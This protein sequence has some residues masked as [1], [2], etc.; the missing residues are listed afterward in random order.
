MLDRL[1]QAADTQ[2]LLVEEA[3]HELR[4][5]I[6]VLTTNAEV[7]LAHPD[8]T[9]ALY[10]EGIERSAAAARRL[11][12]TIEDLLVDAR[13]RARTLDRR[14]ADLVAVA[15]AAVDDA[16]VLAAAGGVTLVAGGPTAAPCAV[17]EPTVR[18]AVGNLLANAVRH[19]PA[20]TTV[21]VDVSV[22]DGD[23]EDEVAVSVTDHG[24]GIPGAEQGRAFERFWRGPDGSGGTGLG[25]PI[26]R[27]IARAHGGDVTLRSPGP[28]G[29][30]TVATITLRRAL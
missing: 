19:A 27:Q 6:A 17:D 18:R 21:S 2:R 24:P 26:A 1:E 30:G 10:R 7:V 4:T 9:P 5:P 16:R 3:S 13:G 29:D 12:A 15:A 28:A 11:A 23:G 22:G 25:L 8:P 14:P 20:G